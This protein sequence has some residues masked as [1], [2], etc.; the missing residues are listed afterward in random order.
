MNQILNI[1]SF[2]EVME[3]F[4]ASF[5]IAIDFYKKNKNDINFFIT[6]GFLEA[7]KIKMYNRLA[8]EIAKELNL[9]KTLLKY[10]NEN[11][12]FIVLTYF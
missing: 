3:I 5:K 2:R 1:F 10:E 9:K 8:D 12:F 11:R 6:G 7:S 4:K